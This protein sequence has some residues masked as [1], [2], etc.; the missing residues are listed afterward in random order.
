MGRRVLRRG[1]HWWFDVSRGVYANF[2]FHV[3]IVPDRHEITGLLAG[4][5]LVARYCCPVEHGRRSFMYV[6]EDRDYCVDQLSNNTR[7]KV[8]RGLRRNDVRRIRPRELGQLG[9][10]DLSRDTIARQGRR[11]PAGHD[12]YWNRYF[13]AAD[14]SDGFEAWGAFAGSRLAAFLLSCN[15]DGCV[16]IFI[17]RSH[18][19][20]LRDY[21]NNALIH[22][23]LL[24]ALSRPEIQL[25]SY[26][27]E[28]IQSTLVSLDS[29][30]VAMNFKRREI[31]Q[32]V[33]LNCWIRPLAGS[34]L[35][36][37]VGQ[38]AERRIQTERLGKLAGMVRWY[39]EQTKRTNA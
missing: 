15:I 16:N 18:R 11:A 3:P 12:D 31:G 34:R 28:S 6:C 30:K 20:T 27:W 37:A 8:R 10:I 35:I 38:F 32:R 17:L 29:F 25:V 24:D 33:E 5:G 13:Q 22:E 26:G 19:D 7:S 1:D 9:G 21:P 14:E 39:S 36:Q 2:P 23:F 4:R